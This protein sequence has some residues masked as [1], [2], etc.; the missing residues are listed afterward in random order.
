M[1]LNTLDVGQRG[2]RILFLHGLFG[3]GRNW[4]TI[5][6]ALADEHRIT[7]VDLPDHGRSPWTERFDYLTVADAVAALIDAS[8]PATVVGH[9]M[10][11]KVAMLLALRHPDLV[12]RLVVADMS[13]VRY[14]E[15][16]G[17]LA[18]YARALDH[19]D[20]SA[21]SGREDAD[22][23]LRAEVDDPTVRSFLL[24]NLRRDSGPSGWRWQANLA[25][26]ERD[27]P[28]IADWP[29]D[30]LDGVAPYQ[31]PVL[32]VAGGRSSYVTAEYEPAMERWFPRH[33]KLVI[34]QAGHWVH[35]EQPEIFTEA[36]RRFTNG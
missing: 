16:P 11:G 30:A 3:Q 20:L 27:M 29:E 7:M 14:R 1:S 33:R 34:K 5:G 12:R 10:G 24:Q 9:S 28:L 36:V 35:S 32:W 21:V 4:M 2:S 22:R 15:T 25:L 6:K 13:P 23:L 26:L 18:R 31:G 19:L 17:G 8:D